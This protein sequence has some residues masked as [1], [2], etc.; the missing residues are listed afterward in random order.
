MASRDIT[1][2]RASRSIAVELGINTDATL[3]KN[4]SEAY[5]VAIGG[6]PFY[7][8]IA[9]DKPYYRQTLPFRKDQF[10][11]SNEPGEQSLTGWWL[12]SQA[13]FHSGS[14]IKF[15][16]PA[17]TDENGHYRFADSK[18]VDVWTKGEVTLLKKVNSVHTVLYQPKANKRVQ[19]WT[20]SIQWIDS[21]NVTHNGVLLTDGYDV[22]KI[23][24][25]GTTTHFIDYNSGADYPVYAICDDGTYAYWVTNK[26]GTNRLTMYKKPLSGDSSNTAD[27]VQMFTHAS[28]AISNAVME[29]TKERIILAVNN[30]IYEVPIDSTS[31]PTAVYTHPNSSYLYTSITSSGSAIYISGYNGIH[32]SI[33]KFTL[34]TSGVMPTLT[35]AITAAEMAV[36][37]IIHR[38]FFYLGFMMIGTSKGIRVASVEEGVFGAGNITYGPI[39]IETNTPCYDFAGH[40]SYVWCAASNGTDTGVIR[41]NL[42]NMITELRPAYSNDS[43]SSD[44]NIYSGIKTETVYTLS[45][46]LVITTDRPYHHTTGCAFIGN[47]NQLLFTVAA[48]SLGDGVVGKQITSNVGFIYTN[49]P[50]GL[51]IGEEFY[52]EGV[53]STFNNI[54]GTAYVRIPSNII[55][56]GGVDWPDK[57]V[58]AFALTASNLAYTAVS[59]STAFVKRTGTNYAQHETDLAPYGYIKTGNIRFNTLEP[60]HFKRIVGRGKFDFGSMSI[61]TVD[62][63]NNE[64]DVISYDVDYGS[65]ESATPEPN[66]SQEYIAYKFELYPDGTYTSQGPTFKGYQAKA[67]PATKRQRQIQFPVLC[68]DMETDKNNVTLGYE[69]RAM[70]RIRALEAIEE[71]GDIVLWQDLT[72]KEVREV[73]IDS[74]QFTRMTPPEKRFNGFGGVINITV[75]TV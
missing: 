39:V 26:T 63:D 68:F 20:R 60:K 5:E 44:L 75:R 14:G 53:D 69:G 17:T 45:G 71:Y 2:G 24:A 23:E 46:D 11:A 3:W 8:G 34:N 10:D 15:Y 58:V 13:S 32:S 30:S 6:L 37:E 4:T 9:T 22:D 70:D 25:D 18:G 48:I 67:I 61:K 43:Y 54:G 42:D 33:S 19:Q 40:N 16:D 57:Y 64:Y 41:M 56:A 7:Y 29:Y 62:K 51:E 66:G 72:T 36:G 52:I 1:E 73:Q 31:L 38:I 28:I 59:S 65:P 47:T 49:T 27:V 55:Y 21:S 35:S 74:I 12:R 50:H